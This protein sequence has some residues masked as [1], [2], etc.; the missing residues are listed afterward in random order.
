MTPGLTHIEAAPGDQVVR[1][2][3]GSAVENRLLESLLMRCVVGIR[4]VETR[5]E[6]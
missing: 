1:D 5:D 2:A 3:L 6:P 4:S